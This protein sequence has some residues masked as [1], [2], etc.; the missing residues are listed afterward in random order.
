MLARLRHPNVCL[1]L[2]C[3]LQP[4]AR[5]AIVTELVPRGSLWDVLREHRLEPPA[6]RNR[7]HGSSRGGR[8]PPPYRTPALPVEHAAGPDVWCARAF[9]VSVES[10]WGVLL[11]AFFHV[12]FVTWG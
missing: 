10:L 6:T 1:F 3:C 8:L 4:P 11:V 7:G 12:G 5:Y 2:G 9:P